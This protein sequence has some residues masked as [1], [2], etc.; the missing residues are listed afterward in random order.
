MRIFQEVVEEDDEFA[1]DGGERDFLGFAGGD[2]PLIKRFQDRIEGR[3]EGVRPS[4]RGQVALFPIVGLLTD[5]LRSWAEPRGSG[6]VVCGRSFAFAKITA[7]G[8][9]SRARCLGLG[10]EPEGRVVWCVADRRSKEATS[11][12]V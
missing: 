5:K 6:C 11:R 1:H 10:A 2:Q 8:F 12:I 3:A 7:Q 4:R 9:G